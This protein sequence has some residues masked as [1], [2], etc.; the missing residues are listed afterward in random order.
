MPWTPTLKS[1]CLPWAL[2]NTA[3]HFFTVDAEFPS[4]PYKQPLF[5][6]DERGNIIIHYPSL[7]GGPEV[8]QDTE[9]PFTRKRLHPDNLE[10]GGPKYVQDKGS[11]VH[12]F[13]PQSIID[14]FTKKGTH[15]NPYP[16]RGRI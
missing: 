15:R 14:K 9:I 7:Y 1:G 16:G 10:A 8:I 3:D 12:L 2:G 4:Q 5:A 6:E 13:H 11:G